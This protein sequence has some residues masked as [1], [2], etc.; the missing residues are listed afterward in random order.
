ML[1]D[2]QDNLCLDLILLILAI[3]FMLGSI[4]IPKLLKDRNLISKLTARKLIHSFG[5][6]TIIFAPFFSYPFYIIGVALFALLTFLI[7]KFSSPNSKVKFF[8][9]IFSAVNEEEEARV[10]YLEG[11]FL[12]SLTITILSVIF[13]FFH[14]WLSI[15]IASILIMMYAD[16]AASFLGKRYGKH[17]LHIPW[18]KNKRTVEGSL[19]FLIIAFFCGF[20]TFL[21]FGYLNVANLLPLSI[22]QTL[23]FSLILSIVTTGAEAIS[24]SKYDD[25][26]VPICGSLL[27]IILFFLFII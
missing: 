26:I 4:L 22:Q 19:F 23:F 24:P 20:G 1:Y 11:P 14:Q 9:K 8:G 27:L 10:N 25:L 15:A 5:G 16:T 12:Y 13:L 2:T 17:I 21:I 3:L 6:L 7:L 18:L